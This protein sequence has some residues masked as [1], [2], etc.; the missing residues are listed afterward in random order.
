M[1]LDVDY[2]KIDGSIIKRLKGDGNARILV[3]AIVSFSRQL[4]IK[5]IAEFVSDRETF[6]IVKE[7]GVNYSQGY[8]FGKPKPFSKVLNS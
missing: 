3:E 7:L 2:L 6:D 1:K 5:T 4:G 8:Y